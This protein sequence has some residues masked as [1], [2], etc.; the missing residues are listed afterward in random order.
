M[1]AP[2]IMTI[3]TE[4]EMA[5]QITTTVT[6]IM[7]KAK[8]IRM[9]TNQTKTTTKRVKR[10]CK[11]RLI[12]VASLRK[13]TILTMITK[14]WITEIL[15]TMMKKIIKMTVTS[16][17]TTKKSLMTDELT[18]KMKMTHMPITTRT[19]EVS[20]IMRS[21]IMTSHITSTLTHMVM[22]TETAPT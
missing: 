3:V 6:A 20:I 1:T 11:I 18:K 8:M 10:R 7:M 13:E 17:I 19:T 15:I 5:T 21:M 9:T 12:T 16:K 2:E 22:M 14:K 4:T